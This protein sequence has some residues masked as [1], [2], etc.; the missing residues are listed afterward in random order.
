MHSHTN[1]DYKKYIASSNVKAALLHTLLLSH[2]FG[3]TLYSNGEWQ[4]HS[5]AQCDD[6][7]YQVYQNGLVEQARRSK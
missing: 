2:G 3:A 1:Y 6:N 5:G 4:V 7:G